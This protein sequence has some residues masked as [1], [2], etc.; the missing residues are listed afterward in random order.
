L[1]AVA[2]NAGGQNSR[3]L[4]IQLLNLW[5]G[6]IVEAAIMQSAEPIET[7]IG[8]ALALLKSARRDH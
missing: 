6:A 7:A 2:A 5:D 8:A 1:E 4:A 3:A